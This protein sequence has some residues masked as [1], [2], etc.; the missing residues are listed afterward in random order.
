M[1][2][3]SSNRENGAS[4]GR[5]DLEKE[6]ERLNEKVAAL[7]DMLERT[8]NYVDRLREELASS[9]EA[10]EIKNQYLEES[11]RFAS[12]IQ[13]GLLP[14]PEDHSVFSEHFILF[15]PKERIGGDLPFLFPAK[16]RTWILMI[17]CSGHGVPGA[18]LTMAAHALLEDILE[19]DQAPDRPSSLLEELNQRLFVQFGRGDFQEDLNHGIDL[20]CVS[21]P[22][23]ENNLVYAGARRPLFYIGPEAEDEVAGTKRSIGEADGPAFQDR[24]MEWTEGTSFYL[25]SDGFP[26]QFG[27]PKN[28]K[29]KKQRLLERI[30]ELSDLE[31]SE[32]KKF[33]ETSFS[34]WKGEEEQTDDV[35]LMGFKK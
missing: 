20:S 33:L 3:S 16:D 31:L 30:R 4:S 22:H 23:Q 12:L 24:T 14:S 9:K 6:N 35:L 13:E 21:I 32:Q 19:G 27:G 26:D 17:D 18:M 10:I 15:K 1:E 2:A 7:E 29:F 34:S 25:F 11:I 8:T 28:K 5:S